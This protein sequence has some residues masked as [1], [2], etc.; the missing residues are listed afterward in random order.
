MLVLYWLSIIFSILCILSIVVLNYL[1]YKKII[2][3][4][5]DKELIF[6]ILVCGLIFMITRNLI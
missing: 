2:D 6:I 1:E 4:N 3:F 5:M